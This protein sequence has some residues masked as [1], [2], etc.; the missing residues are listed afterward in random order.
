MAALRPVALRPPEAPPPSVFLAAAGEHPDALFAARRAHLARARR[1]LQRDLLRRKLARLRHAAVTPA[2][3]IDVHPR[4]VYKLST[5]ARSAHINSLVLDLSHFLRDTAHALPAPAHPQLPNFTRPCPVPRNGCTRTPLESHAAYPQEQDSCRSKPT[6]SA[7]TLTLRSLLPSPSLPPPLLTN[8]YFAEEFSALYPAAVALRRSSIPP[9]SA[10]L[11]KAVATYY[12]H[13]FPP[14]RPV[15]ALSRRVDRRAP[16][17]QDKAHPVPALARRLDRP[18]PLLQ[19]KAHP[20]PAVTAAQP[21]APGPKTPFQT[22]TYFNGM[23]RALE[24]HAPTAPWAARPPAPKP[25]AASRPPG[26]G[27]AYGYASYRVDGPALAAMPALAHTPALAAAGVPAGARGW[28][29]GCGAR[30]PT[31]NFG[32]QKQTNYPFRLTYSGGACGVGLLGRVAERVA[33]EHLPAPLAQLLAEG[34]TRPRGLFFRPLDVAAGETCEVM[35][36]ELAEEI[37]DISDDGRLVRSE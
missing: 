8:L 34:A 10:S 21:H 35:R 30:G 20:V 36:G 37:Y 5:P 23:T 14:P 7:N 6:P 9:S 22:R 12:R 19:D 29:H 4:D 26:A 32:F 31:S 11:C 18:A 13:L 17:L 28:A 27:Y 25:A 16:L 33:V 3:S 1:L 15:P 2:V 24:R